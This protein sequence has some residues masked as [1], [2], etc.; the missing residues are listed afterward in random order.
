MNDHSA[1]YVKAAVEFYEPHRNAEAAEAM[2][3]YMRGQF[4]YFGLRAPQQRVV[5][6]EFIAKHGLPV[7]LLSVLEGLWNCEERELH[8]LGLRLVDA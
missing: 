4:Q 1:Q 5:E 3:A 7:D 2:T 8:Y 6:K